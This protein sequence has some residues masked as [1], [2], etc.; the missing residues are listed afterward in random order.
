MT[1]MPAGLVVASFLAITTLAGSSLPPGLR[2]TISPPGSRT[3]APALALKDARGATVRL[4]DY[5]GRVVLLD[6]WATWC[7]GCKLEMPWFMEF[8]KQYT[9]SGLSAIGVAVDE[10]GWRTV[11]PY[12]AAHRV[13]YPVVLGT[14]NTVEKVF[15]LPPSLPQTLLLDRNGRIAATHSG[16][17]D[18]DKFE[19]DIQQLLDERGQ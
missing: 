16:V 13:S 7:T 14:F 10:E 11:K 18:K 6:F 12:L 2:D 9:G 4:A 3:V 1:N 17:V 19:K 8:E 15:K 5:K